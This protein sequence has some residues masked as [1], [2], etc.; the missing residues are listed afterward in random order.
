MWQSSSSLQF[1]T[2][3]SVSFKQKEKTYQNSPLQVPR[4]LHPLRLPRVPQG[5]SWN[6][7]VGRSVLGRAIT[8]SPKSCLTFCNLMNCNA[9]GSSVLHYLLEFA[10]THVQI[11]WNSCESV[12]PPNNLILCHPISFCL[13]AF[14]AAESFPMS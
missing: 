10:Q 13:Q 9:P 11:C 2:T 7:P 3:N 5:A 8:P 12:M 4:T 6:P 14:P 1:L